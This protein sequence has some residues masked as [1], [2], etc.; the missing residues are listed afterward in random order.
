MTGPFVAACPTEDSEDLQSFFREMEEVW[1]A[2]IE[3]RG[4]ASCANQHA[5][6]IPFGANAGQQLGAVGHD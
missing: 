2:I 4:P 5:N 1:D 6:L 3:V